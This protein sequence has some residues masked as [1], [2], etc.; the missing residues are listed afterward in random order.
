QGDAWAGYRPERK[1]ILDFIID[2]GIQNVAALTGD[3]H[4]FFAGTAYTTGDEA[5]GRAAFPEFVGGSATSTG[6]PEA[7]GLSPD[8]LKLLAQVNPHIDFYDFVHRGYG[9]IELSPT[10][11]GC[12]LKIVDAKTQGASTPTTVA[13]YRVGLGDRIPTRIG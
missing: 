11:A 4:T 10:Q 3:I 12:Q 9:G 6:L 2:N 5:T 13:S 8:T 1:A 7:T